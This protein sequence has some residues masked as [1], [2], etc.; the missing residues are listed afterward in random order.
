METIQSIIS[1]MIGTFVRALIDT[2]TGNRWPCR[3][4]QKDHHMQSAGRGDGRD[5][6]GHQD[7]A[8]QSA[9]ATRNGW[10]RRASNGPCPGGGERVCH[11]HRDRHRL[12]PARH[13][14]DRAGHLDRGL[15][16]DITLRP[17][18]VRLM[19]TPITVALV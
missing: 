19:P 7:Q 11:Q 2:V 3:G 12:R 6:S 1:T 5:N 10:T 18:S 17:S 13:R 4:D 14:G 15:G 9:R 16:S 8:D